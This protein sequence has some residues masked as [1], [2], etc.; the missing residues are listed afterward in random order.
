VT[1][2]EK[3]AEMRGSRGRRDIESPL[4]AAIVEAIRLVHPLALPF[5][6]PNGGYVMSRRAVAKLKWLGLVPGIPDLIV[7]WSNY[8]PQ[9]GFL[10]VKAP[11]GRLS[12]EQKEV[13][14]VLAAQGHRVAIARSVDGA[15]QTLE[16]WGVP[17]GKLT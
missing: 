6:I 2:A 8:T 15:L 7:T 17:K 5:S 1:P 11:D 13:H 3:L 16:A 14:R 12:P 10:E 9:I 4:Q